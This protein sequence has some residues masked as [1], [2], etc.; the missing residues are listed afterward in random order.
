MNFDKNTVIGFSLLGLL[1]FGY[2]YYNSIGQKE[3]E[4]QR[5]RVADSL[6]LI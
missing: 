6:A 2:F 3:I 1:F 4:L 5:K